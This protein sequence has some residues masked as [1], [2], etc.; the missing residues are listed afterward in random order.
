M[1]IDRGDAVRH[2]LIERRAEAELVGT[3]LGRGAIA[4]ARD[5]ATIH[6]TP[7]LP[8]YMLRLVFASDPVG[9]GGLCDQ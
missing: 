4:V 8:G 6:E 5:G 9:S 2:G 1:V 3:D 7:R